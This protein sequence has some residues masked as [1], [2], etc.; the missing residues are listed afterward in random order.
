M[1]PLYSYYVDSIRDFCKHVDEMCST[2]LSRPLLMRDGEKNT[3]SV[4]FDLKLHQVLKETHYLLVLDVKDIPKSAMNL[5]EKNEKLRKYRL[6][7]GQIVHMYNYLRENTNVYEYPL[8]SG[9]MS[10]IDEGLKA[11]EKSKS[12]KD[13]CD[14]YIT[15]QYEA[16]KDLYERVVN[17]QTNLDTITNILNV[18]KTKP[19]YSRKEKKHDMT[20]NLEERETIKENRYNEIS[21][22]GD[23]ILKLIEENKNYLDVVDESDNDWENY[24]EY[25]E[26][27]LL[28]VLTAVMQCS[29]QYL[30]K[31]TE[32][33][34]A[35][36]PLISSTL[37]LE[38]D[39][40]LFIPEMEPSADDNLADLFESIMNDIVFQANFI[41]R[42]AIH[43]G[44]DS[45]TEELNFIDEI[46]QVKLSIG[47]RVRRTME[48]ADEYRLALDEPYN[49]LW[50]D[51]R[52]EFMKQFVM[53]GRTLQPE[54]F[55]DRGELEGVEECRPSLDKFR[56]E[57]EKY[58]GLY[59]EVER[60]ND[61]EVFNGWLLADVRPLKHQLLD[62]ITQWGNEFKLWLLNHVMDSLN[63][64]N[65]FIDK[66]NEQLKPKIKD[67]YSEIVLVLNCLKRVRSRQEDTD[68]MFEPINDTIQ[69]LKDYGK[70]PPESTNLQLEVS[71]VNCV[72]SD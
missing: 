43:I 40:L 17:A 72:F 31:Q 45:Y 42:V 69:L 57:I 38:G 71:R 63:E 60:L 49:M 15:Q 21:V 35:D 11:G 32:T 12:W 13:D 65:E 59:A 61:R 14:V 70:E 3:I 50:V 68:A 64:L 37:Q 47:T 53:Y 4:N 58:E 25:V 18:Y 23:N 8:I 44:D 36:N 52:K 29:L 48:A 62:I 20:L 39:E 6:T 54:D 27:I 26:E 24:L 33:I 16:L 1:F 28:E 5:F 51:D 10:T 67:E 22:L 66:S 34:S 46:N 56:E 2:N 7:L 9:K 30:E 55:N 19:L 41:P